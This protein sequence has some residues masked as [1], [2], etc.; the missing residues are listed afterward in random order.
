M[1]RVTFNSTGRARDYSGIDHCSLTG[2]S[3]VIQETIELDSV[4]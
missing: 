3:V 2:A 4:S 1:S